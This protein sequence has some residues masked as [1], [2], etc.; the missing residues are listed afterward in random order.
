M[1]A[2]RFMF[3]SWC[4]SRDKCRINQW[5]INQYWEEAVK[6]KTGLYVIVSPR[7][8]ST[9]MQQPRCFKMNRPGCIAGWHQYKICNISPTQK[10]KHCCYHWWLQPE[11]WAL[12]TCH[13][14]SILLT[15]TCTW[16]VCEEDTLFWF[17]SKAGRNNENI[18]LSSCYLTH[19]TKNWIKKP[20]SSDGFVLMRQAS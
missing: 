4:G 12:W 2:G 13:V 6:E 3:L 16:P 1:T 20:R 14:T 19:Q 17:V 8:H 7:L 18:F 9:L 5:R 15:L 11:A 10:G